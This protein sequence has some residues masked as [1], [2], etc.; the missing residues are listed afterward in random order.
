MTWAGRLADTI[1]FP[2]GEF[3]SSPSQAG[4]ERTRWREVVGVVASAKLAG[5]EAKIDPAIYVPFYLPARRATKVDLMAALR[6]E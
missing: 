3:L 4:L 1:I 2:A 6:Y 5:L